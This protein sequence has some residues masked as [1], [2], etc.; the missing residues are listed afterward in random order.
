MLKRIVSGAQLW[1]VWPNKPID[2]WVNYPSSYDWKTLWVLIWR[3]EIVLQP[4]DILFSIFQVQ[5]QQIELKNISKKD[6]AV[7]CD[8]NLDDGFALKI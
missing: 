1:I 6:S 3:K 8:S 4:H 5:K 2:V 7:G